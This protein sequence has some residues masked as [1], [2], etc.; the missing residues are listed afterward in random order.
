MGA[1]AAGPTR[2]EQLVAS[3]QALQKVLPPGDVLIVIAEVQLATARATRA[4]A[5]PPRPAMPSI[6]AAEALLLRREAA[7]AAMLRHC[8]E[9]ESKLV[10]A[11]TA[12][13]ESQTRRD[14]AATSLEQARAEHLR[15]EARFV[16][17]EK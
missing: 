17:L 10:A 9:A 2:V 4:A 7:V 11:K 6:R 5:R 1:E 8:E 3:L 13:A 15:P 16:A 14:D 12:L